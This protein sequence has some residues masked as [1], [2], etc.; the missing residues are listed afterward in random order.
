VVL[1]SSQSGRVTDCPQSPHTRMGG[2][3]RGYGFEFRA[4]A[5][6]G[7]DGLTKPEFHIGHSLK[8]EFIRKSTTDGDL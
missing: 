8:G 1:V 3:P 2:V 7:A 6:L 4:C 5:F